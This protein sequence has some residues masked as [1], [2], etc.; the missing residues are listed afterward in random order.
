MTY[1]EETKAAGREIFPDLARAFALIGIALVNVAIFSHPMTTGYANLQGA[2][3]W[4]SFGV[5][6]FFLLKSYTLFSFMFGVGFAYQMMAAERRSVGFA[7]RY[8]RRILGLLIL[9]LLHVALAFQG[10]ILVIYAILGCFLFLFRKASAK[11]LVKWG[12]GL[13]A[14]QFVV[15]LSAFSLFWLGATFAPEQ[16]AAELELNAA[17]ADTARQA[18]GEGGFA[19]ALVQ[20][21]ADWSMV[22]VGG[23]FMQGIG[24]MAF[25]VFGLAAVRYEAISDPRKPVW[26]MFRRYFL[27]IGVAGSMWGG[28]LMASSGSGEMSIDLLAGMTVITLF[29]P[30]STAGYL[31][32]I[33]KWAE[34]PEG[35]VKVF[36]ARGGTAS[37]TAYILQSVVFSLV[38]NNYGLGLYG[39]VGALGCTAIALVVGFGSVSL[40]SLWRKRFSRG[41]LEVILRGW[42]YLG[43]R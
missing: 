12:I 4:A 16:M 13:Y 15:M 26:K 28:W 8:W 32:L 31:G 9:G 39:Q 35:R 38:F 41:P 23:L 1:L 18:F 40:M 6:S 30:F 7:G 11:T 19:D 21:F 43:A 33:A 42:T 2:D 5:N 29:S 17:S 24:A 25:F 14:L 22:L 34:V 36:L 3:Q 27:P 20:R 37:L 10:D